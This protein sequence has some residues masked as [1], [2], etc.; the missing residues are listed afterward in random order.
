[1]RRR[2][3]L[4]ILAHAG[5]RGHRG[6]GGD[7][8]AAGV[9]VGGPGTAI[10]AP[11]SGGSCR[12]GT[13]VPRAGEA[14]VSTVRTDVSSLSADVTA[15]ESAKAALQSDVA[16]L[17]T[18]KTA[19]EDELSA[20]DTRAEALEATL[21]KVSYEPTGTNGKPV[22]R[23]SGRTCSSWTAAGAPPAPRAAWQPLRRPQRGPGHADRRPQ[24]PGRSR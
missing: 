8:C 18:V 5:R 15:L 17:K 14:D 11:D 7:R 13:L 4:L 12:R 16:A 21:S 23:I 1:M 3:Q 6:A 9:C 10:T 2:R 22:L 20:L 24:R 19:L